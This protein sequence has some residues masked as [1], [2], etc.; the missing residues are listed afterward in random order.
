MFF[1]VVVVV[2]VVLRI[3]R[4]SA[5]LKKNNIKLTLQ[6][7]YDKVIV[8]ISGNNHFCFFVRDSFSS[9]DPSQ[10]CDP[11]ISLR[12][13]AGDEEI[14]LGGREEL[15]ASFVCQGELLVLRSLRRGVRGRAHGNDILE[16]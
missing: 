15:Q 1:F 3:R 16:R 5:I 13:G 12:E 4:I 9:D 8:N 7:L 14:F 10:R 11:S 6:S 2:V